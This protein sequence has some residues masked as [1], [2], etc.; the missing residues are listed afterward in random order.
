MKQAKRE[1][2]AIRDYWKPTLEQAE[3][4]LKAGNLK[5]SAFHCV[6]VI[7]HA[8]CYLEAL[9][10]LYQV[11]AREGKTQAAEA[12]IKRAVHINPNQIWSTNELSFLLYRKGER[13]QAEHHARNAIRIAPRNARA[14]SMMAALL[15]EANRN[16]S[17][18]Y[19]YR[20]ALE[21]VEGEDASLYANLALNLK[22]QGRVAES[23]EF[24]R[25]ADA[26]DPNNF[27]T[28]MGWTRMEE[29]RRN[30]DS[31]WELLGRVEALEKRPAAIALVK[32]VLHGREKEYDKALEVLDGLSSSEEMQEVD[33]TSTHLLE[34]GRLYDRL[35]RFDEAWDCYERGKNM[36][37]E[38]SGNSYRDK[39]AAQLAGRLKNFFTSGRLELLPRAER[40]DGVAQPLFVVGF[41]RSGTTMVEQTL[42]AHP[43]LCAGDELTFIGDLTRFTPQMLNSPTKYPESLADLWI[44]ENLGGLDHMRDWY[45]GKVRQLGILEDGVDYFTDKMPLNETHLGFISLLFPQSPIIH[46]IRHPLDVVVSVFSNYLTHGYYCAF[47]LESTARHYALVMD[48]V[49]HYRDNVQMKYM[50]VKYEEIV[51]DQETNVRELLDFIG[52]PFDEKCLNF[53][54]NA[55]YARTASYAQVTEKLYSRSAYRYKN[56]LKHLEPIIPIVE[57]V[58]KRLGY[59]V[60]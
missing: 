30:I 2:Q 24:Y 12:L 25:K 14:H 11:R 44:G 3:A 21:L 34:K 10:I 58:I 39:I 15:T 46:L 52:E 26:L 8:P 33:P 29:A 49:F 47:S 28:L 40:R 36:V 18:E 7:E 42:T 59:T 45:L 22:Q 53:H 35:G 23:E 9:Q 50:P 57:P 56:Y 19:H 20:R 5:D 16:L 13:A 54:E 60:D 38:A 55:R 31:A 48:L 27:N 41:P 32:A 43:K 51:E 1:T 6:H 17:G 4:A 37:R